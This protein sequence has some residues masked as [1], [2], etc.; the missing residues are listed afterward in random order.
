MS[1]GLVLLDSVESRDVQCAFS[2]YDNLEDNLEEEV[3]RL[4]AVVVFVPL[5]C[6]ITHCVKELMSCTVSPHHTASL[7]AVSIFH[8]VQH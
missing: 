1:H 2:F 6:A 5:D 8:A 3:E 4:Q 7:E